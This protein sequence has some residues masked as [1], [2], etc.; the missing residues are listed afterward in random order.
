MA[1]EGGGGVRGDPHGPRPEQDRPHRAVRDQPVS[2]ACT[3]YLPDL[4][5]NIKEP[6]ARDKEEQTGW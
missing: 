4:C 3:K 2:L 5:F 6:A 1:A